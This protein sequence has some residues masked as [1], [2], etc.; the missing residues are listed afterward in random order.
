M[1]TVVIL[2]IDTLCRKQSE[3]LQI[4]VEEYGRYED[5][6]MSFYYVLFRSY[7]IG[8]DIHE[9]QEL[10]HQLQPQAANFEC[11]S[12]CLQ[13]KAISHF[14]ESNSS[15]EKVSKNRGYGS[16][17]SFEFSHT[18]EFPID[19]SDYLSSYLNTYNLLLEYNIISNFRDLSLWNLN[20]MPKSIPLDLNS[21]IIDSIST[22]VQK[23]PT[24][25]ESIRQ[26]YSIDINSLREA[27][28]NT[29]FN[30]M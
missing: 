7:D 4:F 30:N 18:Q 8:L 9:I 20:S 5:Q 6:S 26:S 10:Y 1:D 21:C 17:I 12:F 15:F 11:I 22:I 2:V 28:T 29:F 24:L 3:F 13:E 25:Q 19:L 23:S 14:T 16:S 27:L